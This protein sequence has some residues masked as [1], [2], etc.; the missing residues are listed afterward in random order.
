MKFSSKMLQNLACFNSFSFRPTYFY[1]FLTFWSISMAHLIKHKPLYFR[2]VKSPRCHEI[3]SHP[4]KDV[5]LLLESL[6]IW[7]SNSVK[8]QLTG[9]IALVKAYTLFR[10]TLEK[11]FYQ[12]FPKF[13]NTKT[14]VIFFHFIL[15]QQT[16]LF[17]TLP[18]L[19]EFPLV[20]L[21]LYTSSCTEKV[22]LPK[23]I[24]ILS[25]I[26][27]WFQYFC[28]ILLNSTQFQVLNKEDDMN[29]YRAE[30][31]GQEGLI[32][33]NYIEMRPHSWYYGRITRADAEKLLLN[34][35]EG[36][37][38][39]RVSES[40]PGDF[41]LSVKCGDGVQHFKVLRDAQ[42][43]QR[44]ILFYL[45]IFWRRKKIEKNKF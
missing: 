44:E 20:N 15:V 13:W 40:S 31:D 21:W 25:K 37:F 7:N 11:C 12:T 3:F 4:R 42:G 24:R 27:F 23:K 9:K 41:S 34:K 39:V 29:W 5:D 22:D 33:S 10:N 14:L 6:E 1:Y 19:D 32:P 43:M 8:I 2:R 16:T 18:L 45:N 30:L 38:V 28:L 36:A 17:F 35:H 26:T